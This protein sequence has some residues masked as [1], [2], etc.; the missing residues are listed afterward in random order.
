MGED[1]SEGEDST[2]PRRPYPKLQQRKTLNCNIKFITQCCY[3]LIFVLFLV[4][5]YMRR[6]YSAALHL[7]SLKL[8]HQ[9]EGISPLHCWFQETFSVKS[10][11]CQPYKVLGF[12]KPPTS[13]RFQ[14]YLLTRGLFPKVLVGQVT[15]LSTTEAG[16]GQGVDDQQTIRFSATEAGIGR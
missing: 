13:Y 5:E 10:G 8:E 15:V 4:I 14:P 9:R 12:V 2:G 1:C 7:V 16:L 6:M 3:L 11:G